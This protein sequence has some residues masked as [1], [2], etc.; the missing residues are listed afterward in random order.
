MPKNAFKYSVDGTYLTIM[1]L[2]TATRER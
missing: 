1:V 2:S